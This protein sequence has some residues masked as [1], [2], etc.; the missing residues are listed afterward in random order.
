M[1]FE[2]RVETDSV[3]EI[4]GRYFLRSHKIMNNVEN[5]IH[6]MAKV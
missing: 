3:A 5:Q 1:K 2:K 4:E 6:G